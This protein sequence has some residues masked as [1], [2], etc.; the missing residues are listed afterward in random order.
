[1]SAYVHYLD[2][3]NELIDWWRC[4]PGALVRY[5]DSFRGYDSRGLVI[6]IDAEGMCTVLWTTPPRGHKRLDSVHE[7]DLVPHNTRR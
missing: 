2:Q 5:Y 7:D 4:A 1:M 6:G 3:N